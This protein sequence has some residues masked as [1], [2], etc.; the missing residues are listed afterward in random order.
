[1]EM[2]CDVLMHVKVTRDGDGHGDGYGYAA[3]VM[4]CHCCFNVIS[5][6]E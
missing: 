2:S 5:V 6:N 3:P 1:M 4:L